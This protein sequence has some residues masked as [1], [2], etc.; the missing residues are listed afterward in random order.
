MN[1]DFSN[2]RVDEEAM[3][4][5]GD[6]GTEDFTVSSMSTLSGMSSWSRGSYAYSTKHGCLL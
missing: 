2:A 6:Q 5:A 3:A 4:T 1:R